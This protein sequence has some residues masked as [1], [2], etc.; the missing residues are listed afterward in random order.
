M[1]PSYAVRKAV[2]DCE[3]GVTFSHQLLPPI[4][5]T[6]AA[7]P[8]PLSL[9]RFRN[10]RQQSS[11]HH[12]PKLHTCTQQ[13]FSPTWKSKS[14][15]SHLFPVYIILGEDCALRLVAPSDNCTSRP[16]AM[17]AEAKEDA[18]AKAH[19]VVAGKL[20]DKELWRAAALAER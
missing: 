11:Y 2:S 20:S 16:N 1:G 3:I 14:T 10:N 9:S 13:S 18:G 17:S 7:M 12:G 8:A 5:P 4:P 6:M 15:A 19:I